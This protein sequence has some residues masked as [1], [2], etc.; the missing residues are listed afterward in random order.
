MVA[1]VKFPIG[2]LH[3]SLGEGVHLARSQH[4]AEL[5]DSLAEEGGGLPDLSARSTLRSWPSP[6]ALVKRRM[7]DFVKTR[8]LMRQRLE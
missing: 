1:F 2:C 3:D 6:L 7:S 5:V 4:R 8:A